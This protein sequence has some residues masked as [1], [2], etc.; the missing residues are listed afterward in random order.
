MF[1]FNYLARI[2]IVNL[3]ITVAFYANVFLQLEGMSQVLNLLIIVEFTVLDCNLHFSAM[4]EELIQTYEGTT[5]TM[6][7]KTIDPIG[8]GPNSNLQDVTRHFI[9]LTGVVLQ[10]Q[11]GN[12]EFFKMPISAVSRINF[13]TKKQKYI[14]VLKF[15]DRQNLIGNAITTGINY[16]SMS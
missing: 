7:K 6:T 3:M 11:N 13:M 4:F 15:G 9:L 8:L 2:M 5:N 16:E 1:T 14:K 12:V 10:R